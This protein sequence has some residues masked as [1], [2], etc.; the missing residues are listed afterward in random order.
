MADK[1]YT[2]NQYLKKRNN[3]LESLKKKISVLEGLVGKSICVSKDWRGVCFSSK[4][5]SLANFVEIKM[6]DKDCGG[7]SGPEGGYDITRDIYFP[8]FSY[9]GSKK[10][11]IIVG[12][13]KK[14]WE[15]DFEEAILCTITKQRGWKG[16]SD[17]SRAPRTQFPN[18]VDD[19]YKLYEKLGVPENLLKSFERK[20][21]KKV[22][23]IKS[24][25]G[26][27]R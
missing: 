21:K 19:V 24:V 25:L 8:K 7:Q 2:I 12:L 15:F 11:K 5:Y 18:E 13:G 17:E 22:R 26:G 9:E 10:P 27:F 23:E 1:I 14:L 4:D 16:F 6:F 20:A 3:D